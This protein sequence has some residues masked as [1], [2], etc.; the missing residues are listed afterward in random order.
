MTTTGTPLPVRKLL[1]A[2]GQSNGGVS[3][4]AKGFEDA[5][6]QIAFRNPANTGLISNHNLGSARDEVVLPD[7]EFG[8]YRTLN[9]RGKGLLNVRYLTFFDPQSTCTDRGTLGSI[10][11]M[12]T[13]PGTVQVLAVQSTTE[14]TTSMKWQYDPTNKVTLTR[15]R[16]GSTHTIA[17][18]GT[19]P[20]QSLVVN[21]PFDP[22]LDP[23]ERFTHT[24]AAGANSADRGTVAFYNQYGGEH[25]L[26]NQFEPTLTGLIDNYPSTT[27]NGKTVS[28]YDVTFEMDSGNSGKCFCKEHDIYVGR[29]I[30]F[31]VISGALPTATPALSTSTDYYVTR[32]TPIVTGTDNTY[33]GFYISASPGGPEIEFTAVPAGD[34]RVAMMPDGRLS[35]MAGMNLRCLTGANA[36]ETRPLGDVT[37]TGGAWVCS[38]TTDFT[39]IPQQDDTFT[40]EPPDVQG[41]PVDFTEWAYFLPACQFEGKEQGLPAQVPVDITL[42]ATTSFVSEPATAPLAPNTPFYPGAPV[43]FFE[44]AYTGY[45]STTTGADAWPTGLL[46][47]KVYYIVNYDTTTGG[48]QVSE[49]YDGT[50]ITLSGSGTNRQWMTL[51]ETW[52]EKDNP[53]PPGFNHLHLDGIPRAMQAYTGSVVE[54]AP[55]QP[56]MAFHFGL[57]Q[58]LSEAW[59]EDVYVLNLA[60]G[61]STLAQ[62]TINQTGLTTGIGWFD[63]QSMIHWGPGPASLRARLLQ[64]LDAAQLAATREGVRLEVAGIVFPQGE[65]DGVRADMADR[66]YVNLVNFRDFM[67][68]ELHTRGLWT[69]DPATLPFLQP[70]IKPSTSWPYYA[71]VNAAIQRVADEDPFFRTWSTAAYTLYDTVHYDGVSQNAMAKTAFDNI[72]DLTGGELLELRICQL[73]LAMAGE[74]SDITAIYPPDGSEEAAMCAQFYPEARDHVLE[75]HAW[76]FLVRQTSLTEVTNTRDDWLYA[77]ELPGN[78]GG[79]IALGEDIVSSFDSRAVKIKFSIEMDAEAKRVLYANQAPPLAARYKMKSVDPRKFSSTAVQAIAAYTASMIVRKTMKGE[80]GIRAGDALEQRA[81][82]IFKKAAAI[83]SNQTRDRSQSQAL[84]WRR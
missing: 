74:R 46:R 54:I 66:Y 52:L 26:G 43:K 65:S 42:G 55:A 30:R 53:A 18:A 6:P 67:R 61:G 10:V 24:I 59:G 21:E 62:T 22:P 51:A 4:D 76:D 33:Y 25:D 29:K 64:M 17:S 56:L 13:Y 7:P 68:T 84:G 57:A 79:M 72:I 77:Y 35:T 81:M 39:N 1:I 73:A 34:V 40:I 50:P 44:R 27:I 5:N 75:S 36:G 49:T 69:K 58:R 48:F 28:V 80:E 71:T 78:F 38:V 8:E 41:T 70:L 16:T 15:L 37:F 3:G 82:A 23:N 9:Y 19:L 14:F 60:L 63:P 31:D 45:P 2:L 12:P 20:T 47:G 11:F 32:R 83:D